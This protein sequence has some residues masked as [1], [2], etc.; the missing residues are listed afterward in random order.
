[1]L[2]AEV[3]ICFMGF[4]N[5]VATNAVYEGNVVSA[6]EVEE[7]EFFN[8]FMDVLNDEESL[9]KVS[10]DD[11][12]VDEQEEKLIEPV[13]V[14]YYLLG[15]TRMSTK[16]RKKRMAM[17]LESPFGQQPPTTPVPPKRISRSVN[18]DFILPLDF[19]EPKMRSINEILTIEVFVE[20]AK[21]QKEKVSLPDGL[22]EYLQM[23]E[24]S[25]YQFPWGYQD[26]HVD[27]EFWLVLAC[28]DKS[29][30]GWLKDFHID[31]WVDLMWC[32]R[33]PDV[34]GAMVSSHFLPC[35]LGGNMI[36]CYSNGVRYPVAWRDAE[37]VYFSVNE[38]KRNWCLAELHITTGV[39]RIRQKSQENHQNRQTRTRERKNTKEAG[40]S[41]PKS[42]TSSNSPHWS[43]TSKNDTLAGVEAQRMMGFVLKALTEVAQMSQ[44]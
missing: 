25:N 32:F 24:P 27:R 44:S 28:L 35:T 8:D 30:Q 14:I 29:K 39:A 11:M 1:M 20:T 42:F 22:A 33:Q 19:E 5:E 36:D 13:K 40:N 15:F 6:K 10:L 41:K 16:E 26:I 18:C 3:A 21:L 37:K 9:P 7:N 4:Q 12:N 23:K 34:D 43:I 2:N 31:L 38:P 17:A